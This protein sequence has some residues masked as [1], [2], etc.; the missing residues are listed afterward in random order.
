MLNLQRAFGR[1]FMAEVGYVR[2][3]GGSFS[4][5]VCSARPWIARP[6]RG[7]TRRSAP[8]GYY[9]DSTQTSQYNAPQT[10]VRRRFANHF[11]FDVHYTLSKGTATQGGDVGADYRGE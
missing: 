6:V 7:P 1:T 5:S 8:G 11:S 4:S 10:S 2:A 3:D 9:V